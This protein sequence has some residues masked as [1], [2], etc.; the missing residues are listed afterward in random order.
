MLAALAPA[1]RRLIATSSSNPRT[2]PA[3]ELAA[4]ARRHFAAVEVVVPPAAALDRAR[5]HGPALVTG[6][7]YLLADL[8][9][10]ARNGA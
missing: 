8:E 2:L 1:G 5:E 7:L 6:S 9:A 10:M 4:V 3:E